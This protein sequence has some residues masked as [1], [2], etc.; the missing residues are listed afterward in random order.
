M[1]LADF[2]CPSCQNIQEL[3]FDNHNHMLAVLFQFGA[4]EC[5]RCGLVLRRLPAA[6]A[7][8]VNGFNARNGYSG[9]KS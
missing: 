1:L 7:F 9:S 2:Q 4:P 3:A 8:T 5:E 6:P